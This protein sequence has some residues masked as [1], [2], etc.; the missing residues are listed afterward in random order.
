MALSG[1]DVIGGL[2]YGYGTSTMTFIAYD[3]DAKWHG[4]DTL[5][6]FPFMQLTYTYTK[7]HPK[8]VFNSIYTHK[9]APDI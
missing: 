1:K 7:C 6:A 2:N 8:S 9:I 5:A 3:L 4:T